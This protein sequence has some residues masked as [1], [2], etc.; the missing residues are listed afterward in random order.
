MSQDSKDNSGG[1]STGAQAGI[2]AACG[3]LGL[4]ALLVLAFV[5]MKKRKG[6]QL[7]KPEL[8]DGDFSDDPKAKAA[9]M[10]QDYVPFAEL[11][12]R[13]VK[14]EMPASFVYPVELEG[15]RTRGD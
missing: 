6:R 2:G 8:Q 12:A 11:E 5:L 7:R 9:P 1:L 3:L 10:V 4:A 15:A 14:Q 13:E